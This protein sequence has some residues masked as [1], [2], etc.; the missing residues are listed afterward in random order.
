MI[1]KLRTKPK[2]PSE[3]WQIKYGK[4]DRK[5]NDLFALTSNVSAN[6]LKEGGQ[7][8]GLL[9]HR[10]SFRPGSLNLGTLRVPGSRFRMEKLSLGYSSQYTLSHDPYRIQLDDWKPASQYFSQ[11]L[12]LTGS[13]PYSKYFSKEKNRI[14][15]PYQPLDS[16]Q[17][18]AEGLVAGEDKNSWRLSLSQDLYGTSSILDPG[19]HNL[20]LDT[21]LKLTDN[22]SVTY[23]NYYN[24]KTKELISQTLKI[25][26]DLH[27]WKLD[28]SYSRRNE[29]WE[30]RVTLFNTALPDALRFST[31]D[32][33]RY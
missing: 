27:C 23:G 2:K 12:T 33:K 29:F 16:L 3:K 18:L 26:R 9:S 24:L 21:S 14:F 19:S 32:S 22:W 31:H 7:P 30:Y 1:S 11:A 10:A 13:A 8:F 4:D 17:I 20:R 25:S 15:D 28:L 5:I 6:L